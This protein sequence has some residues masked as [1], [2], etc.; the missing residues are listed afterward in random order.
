MYISLHKWPE[1]AKVKACTI[2]FRIVIC[3]WLSGGDR[4]RL[5]SPAAHTPQR[6]WCIP[7]ARART[8]PRSSRLDFRMVQ[9]SLN[10]GVYPAQAGEKK[11]KV[12]FVGLD[13]GA[14]ESSRDGALLIAGS[15]SAKRSSILCKPR[16]SISAGRPRPSK[17]HAS[18]RKLQN[19]LYNALERP[20]GWAFIYHTYV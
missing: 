11:L 14:P 20:R 15:E 7:A 9:K 4:H 12:G 13:P 2:Q 8:T 16:S 6:R 1:G 10:G 3:N 19:F 5:R 17:K 18:Y